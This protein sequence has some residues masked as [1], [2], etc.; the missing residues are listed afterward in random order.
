MKHPRHFPLT[1]GLAMFAL[2]LAGCVT[3]SGTR[4][5]PTAT[6]TPTST[7]VETTGPVVGPTVT[8]EPPTITPPPTSTP[9]PT[10]TPIPTPTSIPTATPVE[11]AEPDDVGP[12]ALVCPSE[13]VSF[14]LIVNHQFN[15]SPGR[16]TDQILVEGNTGPEASCQLTV[17]GNEV[18]AADCT[19][20]YTN[21][22]TFKGDAGECE[23]SGEGTALIEI[24]GFCKD[25]KVTLEITETQDPDAGLGGTLNCPQANFSEPYVTFYPPS[26]TTES[27]SIDLG[28]HTVTEDVEADPL[29]F[30]Y[31]KQWTLIPVDFPES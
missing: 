5:T 28:G 24:E 19:V 2:L 27:F 16:Q 30:Q 18:D 13:S 7:P 3:P 21:A 17:K 12:V 23:H 11:T 1:L 9:V 10:S 20:S 25:G 31:H 4:A 15:W 6:P 29:G 14:K 8:S 26:L 22:G